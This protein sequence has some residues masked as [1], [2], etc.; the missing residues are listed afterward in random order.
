VGQHW[1]NDGGEACVTHVEPSYL[2]ICR[3]VKKIARHTWL[4][5]CVEKGEMSARM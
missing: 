1:S 4:L 2:A 3:K 5:H